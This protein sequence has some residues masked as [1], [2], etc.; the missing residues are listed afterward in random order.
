MRVEKMVRRLVGA[1]IFM[2]PSLG[3]FEI[4][5]RLASEGR[6]ACWAFLMA[7]WAA[8]GVAANCW[9]GEFPVSPEQDRRKPVPR[10][11]LL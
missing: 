9:S 11:E 4:A 1:L 7:G 2:V 6:G 3:L 8:L 5:G 10:E